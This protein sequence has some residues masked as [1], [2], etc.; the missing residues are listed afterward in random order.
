MMLQRA[1]VTGGAGFIGSHLVDALL[2]A[3]AQ[4]LVI[5]D[6]ST[7]RESNLSFANASRA[8]YLQVFAAD[9]RDESVSTE[10]VRFHPDTIFHLAAQANVR[11]SVDDPVFDASINVAGTVRMLEASKQAG[12]KK[13]IFASTGGAI[14]GEQES[15]PA[16]EDH[17]CRA[18]CP[19]G[20]SK[21]CGELYL[22]YFSRAH[23]MSAIALRYANVYGPRQSPK[24]EAG[25][26][27]IFLDRLFRDEPFVVHGDGLQTRDF[28]HVSD[29]VRANL[30][31]SAKISTPG[32][33]MYNVG[34]AIESTVLD[35]VEI[36]KEHSAT[37]KRETSLDRALEIVIHHGPPLHGEQRRSVITALK[38]SQEFD[39]KPQVLL[40]NGLWETMLSVRM[41]LQQTQQST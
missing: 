11:K 32:F 26:V 41:K 5:D 34:T 19:Y 7:G 17:P 6:F 8:S 12:T 2:H 35:I 33:F 13:F 22:E 28:I 16:T 10:I 38:L 21:R 1:V 36:L 14:Y 27:A 3:G 30:Q 25:V 18:E 29:V 4:V 39:W 20:V 15:F 9:I 40:N 23:G 31:V 24:G 37:L